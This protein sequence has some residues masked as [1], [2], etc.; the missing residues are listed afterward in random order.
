MKRRTSNFFELPYGEEELKMDEYTIIEP[1]K[2]SDWKIYLLG[3][4]NNPHYSV[5]LGVVEGNV[6]NWFHRK[7]QEW[8]FGF[9][10]RKNNGKSKKAR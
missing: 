5:T 2:Q 9:K 6:K 8:C 4:E 3:D 1:P 7:M 10:W